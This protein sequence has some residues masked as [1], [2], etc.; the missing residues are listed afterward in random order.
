MLVVQRG[1]DG[2]IDLAAGASQI[3]PEIVAWHAFAY[4]GN[5]LRER[6]R[7]FARSLL[8]ATARRAPPRWR[9]PLHVLLLSPRLLWRAIHALDIDSEQPALSSR[10]R[11]VEL[12]QGD[13]AL[14]TPRRGAR[15]WAR[16]GHA[17]AL[18]RGCLS[19]GSRTGHA[20]MCAVKNGVDG[21]LPVAVGGAQRRYEHIIGGAL[22]R[23]GAQRRQLRGGELARASGISTGFG[24][25]GALRAR[26]R[27]TGTGP[28][29]EI[30][31]VVAVVT[32]AAVALFGIAPGTALSC[33]SQ[34]RVVG[35]LH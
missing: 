16:I 22:T 17:S 4:H 13:L 15:A 26:E 12:R 14:A 21:K 1:A 6:V 32:A 7:L 24:F 19:T 23:E 29:V 34:A 31:A 10:G 20:A 25:G 11:D 30:A 9:R 8:C 3:A 5:H 28:K 27:R 2:R 35:A 18:Q 33:C